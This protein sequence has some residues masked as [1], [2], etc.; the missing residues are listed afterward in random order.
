MRRSFSAKSALQDD[1]TMRAALN[2]M[3]VP[4][5]PCQE[6]SSASHLERKNGFEM[7]TYSAFSLFFVQDGSHMN[8]GA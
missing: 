8:V 6:R 3:A 2:L 4:L 7:L 1:I 5:S